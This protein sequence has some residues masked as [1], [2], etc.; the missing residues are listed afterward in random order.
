MA[1]QGAKVVNLFFMAKCLTL[2]FS[3]FIDS[4]FLLHPARGNL[5]LPFAR[6]F[7]KNS[8]IIIILT[9]FFFTLRK[10]LVDKKLRCNFSFHIKYQSFQVLA[11]GVI[12][13]DGVVGGLC[14]LVKYA[15]VAFCHCC[16]CEH[17]CAEILFAHYLR[18]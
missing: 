14:Q 4:F 15:H 5:C 1:F 2:Y 12:Y 10:K 18:A 8:S 3:C 11:F 17:R 9:R 7:A 13:A 6:L 16:S